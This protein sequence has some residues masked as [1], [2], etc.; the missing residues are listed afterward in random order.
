MAVP[1]TT[2]RTTPVGIKLDDGFST[3][4]TP[5]A[6]ADVSFW[7]KTVQPPGDDGGDPISTTTMH[8]TT[9]RTKAARQLIDS[10]DCVVVGAYDPAVKTQIKSLINVE[11]SWT[12]TY[13]DGSTEDFF[14]F[15]RT[16]EFSALAEGEQPEGTFTITVTNWDPVNNVEQGSVIT[17]VAGT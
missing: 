7:E 14:G 8:N 16:A 3:K 4:I 2:A 10:T 15:L 13:P 17:E 12:I 9:Y 11:T 6:D 1:S 5:A